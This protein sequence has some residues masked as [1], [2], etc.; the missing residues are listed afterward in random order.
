MSGGLIKMIKPIRIFTEK[1]HGETKDW[2]NN[3]I[4]PIR[5]YWGDGTVGWE[6]CKKDFDFYKK[7]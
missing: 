1:E 5:A 3:L 7:I 2:S 6:N 4:H